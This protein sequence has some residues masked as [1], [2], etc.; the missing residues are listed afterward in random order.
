MRG[1][2]WRCLFVLETL[3][4]VS[5]SSKRENRSPVRSG[6]AKN[7]MHEHIESSKSFPPLLFVCEV[8]SKEFRIYPADVRKG[9]GHCCSVICRNRR[10]AERNRRDPV[11]RFWKFVQKSDG[12]W[13]WIGGKTQDGYGQMNREGRNAR[14]NR[15]SWELHFGGIPSGL[16]VL[17]K[18]DNP[19]CVRPE[20]LFLGT[21]AD[22]SADCRRK[23]RHA[24]GERNGSAKL[25]EILAAQIRVEYSNGGTSHGKLAAKY[26]ISRGAMQQLLER[27]TWKHV[28]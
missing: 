25:T 14:A 23:G 4:A 1:M 22:N 11:E 19:S 8:C 2:L 24:H 27:K 26:G 20:H 6:L 18:C 12:C 17:H 5:V 16:H 9:G 28:H 13:L 10:L 21:D 15:Y 3:L 7:D